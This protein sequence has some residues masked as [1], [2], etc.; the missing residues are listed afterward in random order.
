MDAVSRFAG[1][2]WW[3][4]MGSVTLAQPLDTEAWLLSARVVAIG[5]PDVHR[6]RQ[7]GRFHSGEP[8]PANPEFL[9]RTAAGRV[10]DPER[11]LV[12]LGSNL[13]AAAA[14]AQQAP[15]VVVSIDLSQAQTLIVAADLAAPSHAGTDAGGAVQLYTANAAPYVNRRRNPRATAAALAAAAGPRYLSINNAFGRPWIANAPAGL[16]GAGNVSVVDPNG[17]PLA[18]PPSATAGGVFAG[19]MTPRTTVPKAERSGLLAAWFN[20]RASPQ[21]TPGALAGGAL[22]TAFMG[23]SPDGS[24]LAVFA[25]ATADGAVAQVHVQDGVDGLAAAG[26]ISVDGTRVTTADAML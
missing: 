3:L 8:I 4:G 16:G 22:G 9:M 26:T 7:G 13:G 2:V 6:V 1:V 12:A 14:D 10:L 21:L 17:A 25:V 18:N 5:L 19:A 11:V 24:G 23:P 20:H 15:G